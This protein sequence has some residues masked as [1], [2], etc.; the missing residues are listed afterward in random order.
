MSVCVCVCVILRKTLWAVFTRPLSERKWKPWGRGTPL[1]QHCQTSIC[2]CFYERFSVPSQPRFQLIRGNFPSC[3]KPCSWCSWTVE[4][5]HMKHSFTVCKKKNE[6]FVRS[7]EKTSAIRSS[8]SQQL[9]SGQ[10]QTHKM[11]W[12]INTCLQLSKNRQLSMPLQIENTLR[13]KERWAGLCLVWQCFRK[14]CWHVWCLGVS[15]G[16]RC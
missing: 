13:E 5:Q 11:F 10:V 14:I 1:T 6:T 4:K 3:P 9:I 2:F 15:F 16:Q 8:S 12:F 7:A